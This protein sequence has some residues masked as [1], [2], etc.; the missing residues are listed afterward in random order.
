MVAAT[1]AGAVQRRAEGLEAELG[2]EADRLVHA[3][4]GLQVAGAVTQRFRDAK[5]V[6]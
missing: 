2:V 6:A 3:R 4:E 1:M 5:A